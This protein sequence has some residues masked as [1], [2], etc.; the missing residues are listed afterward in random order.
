M[1]LYL[2][3]PSHLQEDMKLLRKGLNAHRITV[4]SRWI[5]LDFSLVPEE[6]YG[7]HAQWDFDDIDDAHFV[8]LYNPKAVHKTGTGGRHVETGYA[9]AKGI[10]IVYI[11]E[12]DENVFH[13]HPGVRAMIRTTKIKGLAEQ[14]VITLLNFREGK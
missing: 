13:H 10:P 2:A 4:T 1:K 12:V 3:A 6:E 5:D 11:G 7:A 9:L 14:I 8:I